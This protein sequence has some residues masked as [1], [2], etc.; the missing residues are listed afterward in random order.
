MSTS[1]FLRLTDV[2]K[3]TGLKRASIY[4]RAAAGTFPRPV[5]L[6]ARASGWLVSELDD[7]ADARVRES[8]PSEE[9]PQ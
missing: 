8:R 6:G 3:F 2:E 4:A 7:W 1:K 5:K 9:E